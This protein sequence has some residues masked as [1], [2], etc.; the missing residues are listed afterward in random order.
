[1][2][3]TAA[4]GETRCKEVFRAVVSLEEKVDLSG[5]VWSES[6]LCS[7]CALQQRLLGLAFHGM[8]R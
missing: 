3:L 8:N 2:E 7:L 6:W 1:V 4:G 5:V